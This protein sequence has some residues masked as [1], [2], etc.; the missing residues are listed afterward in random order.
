MRNHLTIEQIANRIR[1]EHRKYAHVED[2]DWAR[3]AAS[4]LHSSIY[5]TPEPFEH[6]FIRLDTIGDVERFFDENPVKVSNWPIEDG[7]VLPPTVIDYQLEH[8]SAPSEHP[9]KVMEGYGVKVL[10]FKGYPIGGFVRMK[11]NALPEA[12]SDPVNIPFFITVRHD[13]T[14]L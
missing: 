8:T 10:G 6:K 4:K 1:D 3:I 14:E 7:R 11:L 5:T 13:I 9:E 12:W 2:M